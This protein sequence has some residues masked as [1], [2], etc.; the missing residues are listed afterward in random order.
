MNQIEFMYWLNGTLEYTDVN[1]MSEAQAK[2]LLAG[3][4]QHMSLVFNKVTDKV[5]PE[6]KVSVQTGPRIPPREALEKMVKDAEDAARMRKQFVFRPRYM[7]P[8]VYP[9]EVQI[10]LDH[11]YPRPNTA[12]GLYEGKDM[13]SRLIC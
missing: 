7:P 2:K 11:K 13:S 1:N 8:S 4:K 10:W 12:T 6:P 5:K 9:P 3:I